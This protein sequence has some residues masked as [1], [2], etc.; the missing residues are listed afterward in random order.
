MELKISLHYN[1]HSIVVF[2][3]RPLQTSA[4]ITSR[5][6]LYPEWRASGSVFGCYGYSGYTAAIQLF[7]LFEPFVSFSVP[8]STAGPERTQML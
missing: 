4:N 3:F 8:E 5:L 7:I 6:K 1:R 2:V